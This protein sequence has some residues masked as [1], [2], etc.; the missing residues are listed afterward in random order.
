MNIINKNI[1]NYGVGT[2]MGTLGFGIWGISKLFYDAVFCPFFIVLFYLINWKDC[3][4]SKDK[5]WT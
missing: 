5:K 1:L 4:K 2:I 3:K